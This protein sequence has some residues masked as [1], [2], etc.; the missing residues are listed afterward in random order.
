MRSST[1]ANPTRW[2]QKEGGRRATCVVS[3][4]WL[5]SSHSESSR[6]LWGALYIRFGPYAVIRQPYSGVRLAALVVHRL[7]Q[8]GDLR[9]S[10]NVEA[11]PRAAA[12]RVALRGPSAVFQRLLVGSG[13]ETLMG[14]ATSRQQIATIV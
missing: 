13:F 2:V 6:P 9:P 4:K 14:P 3:K 5:L 8:L 7:T 1:L 11:Q 12:P 10:L